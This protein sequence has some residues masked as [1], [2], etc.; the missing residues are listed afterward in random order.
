[1]AGCDDHPLDTP[2]AALRDSLEGS[3]Q[4]EADCLCSSFI[5]MGAETRHFRHQKGQEDVSRFCSQSCNSQSKMDLSDALKLSQG[6]FLLALAKKVTRD[7]T[8]LSSRM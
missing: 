7:V 8:A 1:M 4:P 5:G 3:A 6:A 2:F